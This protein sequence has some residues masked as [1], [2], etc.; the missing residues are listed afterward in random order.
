MTTGYF[1]FKVLTYWC[2]NSGQKL[3][4]RFSKQHLPQAIR[5]GC[6]N[7]FL[8][9]RNIKSLWSCM[10]PLSVL[11][12]CACSPPILPIC[13]CVSVKKLCQSFLPLTVPQHSNEE[14]LSLC[15]HLTWHSQTSGKL[16][17]KNETAE[18]SLL[19][20]LLWLCQWGRGVL[21]P[22]HEQAF[23]WARGGK[24]RSWERAESPVFTQCVWRILHLSRSLWKECVGLPWADGDLV[25]PGE[26]CMVPPSPHTVLPE[27]GHRGQTPPSSPGVMGQ[28][29]EPQVG[30][31][32]W[33]K[34]SSGKFPHQ[35]LLW[36][37]RKRLDF[38]FAGKRLDISPPP[39]PPPHLL[40]PKALLQT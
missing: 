12:P 16:S 7:L 20:F 22:R 3:Q 21:L 31:M 1:T 33:G 32:I 24:Q 10:T 30:A 17:L 29:W 5:I 13:S 11:V 19:S 2:F 4:V 27:G 14:L 26:L 25:Q 40:P 34:I 37:A 9:S 39:P 6:K 28:W 18:N 8:T 23:H 38:S 36:L 35:P 15:K